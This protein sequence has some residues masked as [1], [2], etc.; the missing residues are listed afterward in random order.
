MVLEITI[1]K[2][3]ALPMLQLFFDL[4]IRPGHLKSLLMCLSPPV[5]CLFL[6]SL[7]CILLVPIS[8][9]F[10]HKRQII[11]LRRPLVRENFE[12]HE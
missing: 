12:Q 11:Y 7:Y 1:N 8:A 10:F 2:D 4:H 6:P 9:I 5:R 3:K